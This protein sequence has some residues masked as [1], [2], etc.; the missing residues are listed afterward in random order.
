M[1]LD[2]VSPLYKSIFF[3]DLFEEDTLMSNLFLLMKS[4]KIT[5]FER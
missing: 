4:T 5:V 1:F 2:S 3:V